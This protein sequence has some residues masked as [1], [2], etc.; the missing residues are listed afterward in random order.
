M[1]QE[2]TRYNEGNYFYT[3]ITIPPDA[4]TMYLS[5]SGARP[6]ADG[7][8]GDMKQQTVN[9]FERFKQTLE[10]QGWSMSD[11]VQVR[12]F[13]VA[14]EDGLDFAGFNEGYAQFFGTAENP[15][16]PVRSFVEIADLVVDGWLVEIEI[17][18]ARMPD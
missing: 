17:R 6:L 9:T 1:A 18:A 5:G 7:S 15:N 14:G 16:K 2:I 8:W 10:E 12:A 11:I 13:A 3:S 4:E